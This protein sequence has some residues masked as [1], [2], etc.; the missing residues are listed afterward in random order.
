MRCAV[1]IGGATVRS[2]PNRGRSKRT[3][4]ARAL[5]RKLMKQQVLHVIFDREEDGR[6]I[7][8]VSDLP[9]VMVYGESKRQALLRVQA[10]AYRVIANK[11]EDENKL[12][13]SVTF[14]SR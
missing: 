13:N 1:G 9:G 12:Q 10:L 11:I 14:A 5:G 8:E 3:I 2:M 7:A 4:K 6:W